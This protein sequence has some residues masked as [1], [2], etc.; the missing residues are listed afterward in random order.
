[1]DR[2]VESAVAGGVETVASPLATGCFQWG[3]AGVAGEVVGG[4]KPCD[5]GDVAE[6]LP[7]DSGPD[8]VGGRKDGA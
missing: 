1:V 6:D 4:R 7:G 2:G 8:A 3:G 5:I